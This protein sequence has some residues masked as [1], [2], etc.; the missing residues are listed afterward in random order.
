MASPQNLLR[1]GKLDMDV[2]DT[3]FAL[4]K[5]CQMQLKYKSMSFFFSLSLV[6]LRFL[7][8]PTVIVWEC[9]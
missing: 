5:I 3:D 6:I 2:G 8:G 9:V 7:I 4:S 1:T